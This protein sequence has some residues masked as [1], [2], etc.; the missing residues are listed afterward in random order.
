MT[1]DMVKCP[2]CF[3]D[4]PAA[5]KVCLHC[6][7]DEHGFGPMVRSQAVTVSDNALLKRKRPGTD[8][9][10]HVILASD[11]GGTGFSHNVVVGL[12]GSVVHFGSRLAGRYEDSNLVATATMRRNPEGRASTHNLNA[13]NHVRIRGTLSNSQN[14]QKAKPALTRGPVQRHPTSG[15]HRVIFTLGHYILRTL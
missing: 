1:T 11:S 7:R 3:G 13:L 5:A 12:R 4:K 14:R 10:I 2:H 6:G 15:Q 8:L 9:R